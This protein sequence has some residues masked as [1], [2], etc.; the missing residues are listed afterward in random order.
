M[1]TLKIRTSTEHDIRPV[2][3]GALENELR[4]LEAGMQRSEH[5]LRVFEKKYHMDTPSFIMSYE[6]DEIAETVEFAEWVGEYRMLERLSE[7]AGL[8]KSITLEN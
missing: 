8:L 2:L 5:N 6:N 7:K 1:T 3:E 4:L